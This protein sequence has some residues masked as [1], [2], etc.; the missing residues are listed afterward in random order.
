MAKATSIFDVLGPIMIGP[1]S[2]H[3]AGIVRIGAVAR[4]LL[5]AEPV[6]AE[7]TFYNSLAE[8]Y[9]GHGSDKAVLGGIMGFAT[10]DSRIRT[11]KELA[12]ERQLIFSYK[13]IPHAPKF[14][15]NSAKII[16]YDSEGHKVSVT[17]QSIGGG[18][19]SIIDIDG[20]TT[21]LSVTYF[22]IVILA[23]DVKGSISHISAI[24]SEDGVNVANMNVTRSID[25]KKAN[26]V[27]EIDTPLSEEASQQLLAADWIHMVRQ[28]APVN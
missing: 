9:R 3:S 27:I 23:D 16:L 15:P 10:D 8:T 1:S 28:I 2:S 11:A 17:G 5:G 7:I 6:K 12:E 19:I 26:M 4:Q 13:E 20:Y 22:T 14:H 24:I 18:A 21:R 25:G